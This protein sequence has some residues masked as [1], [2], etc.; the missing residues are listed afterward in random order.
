M[1]TKQIKYL[2][3]F[4]GKSMMEFASHATS[5]MAWLKDRKKVKPVKQQKLMQNSSHQV[6]L[7]LVLLLIRVISTYNF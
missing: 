4:S 3:I 1:D 7:L 2:L 5:H 6:M